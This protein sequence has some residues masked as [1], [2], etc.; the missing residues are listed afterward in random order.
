[1]IYAVLPCSACVKARDYINV[2]QCPT[3][4]AWAA[5]VPIAKFNRRATWRR[6]ERAG[7]AVMAKSLPDVARV[8]GMGIPQ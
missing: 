2:W 8:R 5:G 3:H 4:G 6:Y 1:M 7:A